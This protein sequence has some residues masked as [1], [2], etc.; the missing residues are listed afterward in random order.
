MST[1]KVSGTASLGI[2][3]SLGHK[4]GFTQYDNVS[5]QFSMTIQREVSGDLTDEQLLE[6]A[7]ELTDLCRERIEKKISDELKEANKVE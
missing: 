2:K 4:K 3:K 6:K 1:A 7:E 5:P